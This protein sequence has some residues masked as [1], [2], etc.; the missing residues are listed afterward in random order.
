MSVENKYSKDEFFRFINY[1]GKKGLIKS[2]TTNNWRSSANALF[3]VVGDNETQDLRSV[4]VDNI[5]NQY[6]NL[7]KTSPQSLQIY[8]SR[9]KGALDDFFKYVEN[10][11]N[12]KPQISQRT[13]K[14][15]VQ[16]QNIPVKKIENEDSK[17]NNSNYGENSSSFSQSSV[18]V[19][20][21]P[22]R[23]NLIVQIQGLPH[24]LTDGE[25]EKIC[26]V[27]KALAIQ[28]KI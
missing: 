17:S 3:S 8:Q 26:A 6:A 2:S 16:T 13:R 15:T 1:V 18:I 7:R 23:Q 9:L 28:R 20:P 5:C 27:I 22:I 14:K 4:N 25:A 11:I 21:I 12:Y 24:D 10:P 19:F